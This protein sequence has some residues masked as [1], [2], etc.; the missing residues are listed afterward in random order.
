MR[1]WVWFFCSVLKISINKWVSSY[2]LS[3]S[4]LQR[5]ITECLLCARCWAM[6]AKLLNKSSSYCWDLDSRLGLGA[7]VGGRW[8]NDMP[9][10][11]HCS[12]DWA[13]WRGQTGIRAIF[14]GEPEK[15]SGYICAETMK[16]CANRTKHSKRRAHLVQMPL[17]WQASVVGAEWVRESGQRWEKRG[18]EWAECQVRCLIYVPSSRESLE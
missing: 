10:H 18:K 6:T 15:G 14:T 11:D 16:R 17:K 13:E 2:S 7:V 5:I 1:Q 12:E 4:S 9:G 8:T 3:C